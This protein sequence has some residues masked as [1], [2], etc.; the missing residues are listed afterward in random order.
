LREARGWEEGGRSL[1]TRHISQLC[2]RQSPAHRARAVIGERGND[3]SF[4]WINVDNGDVGDDDDDGETP[5]ESSVVPFG[6][7]DGGGDECDA[8]WLRPVGVTPRAIILCPHGGP[9]SAWA[10][11][12]VP[13]L[14][15]WWWWR[16]LQGGGH[17]RLARRISCCTRFRTDAKASRSRCAAQSCDQ[18]RL[19]GWA[20]GCAW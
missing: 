1:L 8:V 13:S 18:Y 12:F 6:G 20:D 3:G 4:A 7:D 17:W 19:D 2:L 9:H 15:W 10:S 14:A 11:A 5:L 16:R